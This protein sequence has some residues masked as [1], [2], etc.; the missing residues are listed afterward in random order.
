M[1]VTISSLCVTYFSDGISV[2]LIFQFIT[3]LL[4]LLLVLIFF[5]S[6]PL[7]PPSITALQLKLEDYRRKEEKWKNGS[8]IEYFSTIRTLFKNRDYFILFLIYSLNSAGFHSL[9]TLL[10]QILSPYGYSVRQIGWMG[11][12]GFYGVL[13]TIILGVLLDRMRSGY[14]L[15]MFI[16]Y[17]FSVFFGILWAAFLPFHSFVFLIFFFNF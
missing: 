11:T 10:N 16:I 9:V 6:Y 17:A 2:I 12:A 4:S 8:K 15:M 5:Q 1:G 7:K 13:G 3:S 14:K